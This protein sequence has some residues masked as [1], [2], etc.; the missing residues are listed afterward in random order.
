MKYMRQGPSRLVIAEF[1]LPRPSFAVLLCDVG[2]SVS[3]GRNLST[4]DAIWL[5]SGGESAVASRLVWMHCRDKVDLPGGYDCDIGHFATFL[6]G[7]PPSAEAD[8]AE[9]LFEFVAVLDS[10]YGSCLF[11]YDPHE[12]W[13]TL[14][15]SDERAC[16]WV[17][18]TFSRLGVRFV[19]ENSE[20]ELARRITRKDGIRRRAND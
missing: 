15:A 19:H 8:F 20:V 5:T 1:A 16:Q 12:I 4:T 10:L 7:W 2:Q 3:T 14:T 9:G 18:E 6:G 17:R 13:A 11:S